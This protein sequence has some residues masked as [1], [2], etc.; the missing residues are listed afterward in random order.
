MTSVFHQEMVNFIVKP[1]NLPSIDLVREL[2]IP[3]LKP[4]LPTNEEYTS[5]ADIN[6][7]SINKEAAVYDKII[8]AYGS[9]TG[10]SQRFA[11]RISMDLVDLATTGPIPLDDLPSCL[12]MP[13][14]KGRTLVL[15]I[16][17]THRKGNAP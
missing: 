9:E 6:T 4:L 12:L 16:T 17:S 7:F 5:S 8:I 1:H 15:V 2:V 13:G 14:C 10:R 11:T 3:P